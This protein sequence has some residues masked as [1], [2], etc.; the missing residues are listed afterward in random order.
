MG[1]VYLVEGRSL[2]TDSNSFLKI[3]AFVEGMSFAEVYSFFKILQRIDS[4]AR[5]FSNIFIR[6]MIV[7]PISPKIRINIWSAYSL[8]DQKSD[9]IWQGK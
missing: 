4:T 7:R 2:L 1:T 3:P 5:G 6:L 8:P 9:K